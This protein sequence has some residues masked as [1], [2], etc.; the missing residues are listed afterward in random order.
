[1]LIKINTFSKKELKKRLL[2]EKEPRFTL[3]FYKYFFVKS[4]IKFRDKIYENFNKYNVLGRVYI[5]KE[6]INAQMSVPVKLYKCWKKFLYQSH[7]QLNNLYINKSL[8]HNKLSFWNLCVK[9][10]KT[11]V[12]DGIKKMRFNPNHV[13][14]YLN[15]KETNSMINDN[16]SIFVDMRNS[17]EYAIG[18]FPKAIEIKSSTF[19]DQLKIVVK[20]MNYAKNKKIVMYCTGGIRC[21]KATS[22][23]IFNGFKYIYHLKGGIIGYVNNAKKNNLPILFQGSNFVFDG[24]MKEKVS[25]NI[26]SFC[27]QC[28]KS[29]DTYINCR[30]NRCHLLFIQCKKCAIFFKNCCS[31]DCMKKLLKV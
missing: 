20:M 10:K 16:E 11:I 30:Y 23:M 7:L 31:I 24:R 5:A 26:I 12:A 22:W 29:S 2:I 15:S 21:E 8:D 28:K 3:S 6:G 14:I 27:K 1:M 4:P 19:R 25:N 9:I 18:H 13:G 17:Y